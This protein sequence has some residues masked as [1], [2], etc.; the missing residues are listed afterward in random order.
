MMSKSVFALAMAI[1]LALVSAK[2]APVYVFTSEALGISCTEA[3]WNQVLLTMGNATTSDNSRRLGRGQRKLPGCPRWCGKYCAMVGVGCGLQGRRRKL[4][5][6]NG[7]GNGK[8]SGNGGNCDEDVSACSA[9][10]AAIDAALMNFTAVSNSC[11]RLL[12][13]EKSITCPDFTTTDCYIKGLSAW[14][15]KASNTAPTLLVPK[16]NATG[17]NFCSK[18]EL[19]LLVDTNFVVGKLTMSLFFTKSLATP[20]KL[21]KAYEGGAAPYYVFGSKPKTLKDG[22]LSVQVS[23]KKMDAV[24]W[25]TLNVTAADNPTDVKTWSFTVTKC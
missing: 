19:A 25:Y 16:M 23:H 20:M 3:E 4:P 2:R 12:A 18:T 24:G 6:N 10:I 11:Q 13:G 15:T 7:N 17:T 1:A 22:T 8:G 5:G 9:D 14:D 21:D